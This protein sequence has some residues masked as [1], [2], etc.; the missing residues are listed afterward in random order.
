MPCDATAVSGA[1]CK[2][3]SR[4]AHH[5]SH[6]FVA[7]ALVVC[8]HAHALQR[9][10]AAVGVGVDNL[11]PRSSE[12]TPCALA[13]TRTRRNGVCASVAL[14]A[15]HLSAHLGDGRSRSTGCGH[16]ACATTPL[17][18]RR[19]GSGGLAKV[20]PVR[21]GEA[22]SE[23][24]VVLRATSQV[25]VRSST[26]HR[27]SPSRGLEAEATRNVMVH[28]LRERCV[29]SSAAC[30]ILALTLC[31]CSAH[32]SWPESCKS[33]E[34]LASPGRH[35]KSR[36]G[37]VRVAPPTARSARAALPPAS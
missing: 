33:S 12:A 24:Y 16:V 3:L 7:Y 30:A 27:V 22:S 4:D 19:G 14:P 21:R 15:A 26:L 25:E 32:A 23:S 11:R 13:G 20:Q 10:Q 37:A 8:D 1:P 17:L 36:G 5:D 6:G 31:S 29:L 18:Q 9:H 35:S 2:Q 34:P 28:S